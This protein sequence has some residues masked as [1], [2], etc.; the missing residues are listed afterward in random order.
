MWQQG[1]VFSIPRM[2]ERRQVRERSPSPLALSPSRSYSVT[3]E[4]GRRHDAVHDGRPR[5]ERRT[6]TTA[7]DTPRSVPGPSGLRSSLDPVGRLVR[8]LCH[9]LQSAYCGRPLVR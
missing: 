6:T 5:A 1:Q 7:G 8:H 2:L 3:A 9:V 4:R